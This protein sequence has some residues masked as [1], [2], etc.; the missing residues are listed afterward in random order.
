MNIK[1]VTLAGGSKAGFSREGNGWVIIF[2]GKFLQPINTIVEIE[3]E[4]NVMNVTPAEVLS[5]SLSFMKEV[6]GSSNLKA[7]WINHQWVDLK[8]VNNGDWSGSFWQPAEDD[9][10]PWI[11]INM[12]K[13]VKFSKVVIYESVRNITSFE[14]QYKTGDN[15]NTFYKGSAIGERAELSFK[16]IEAQFIRMVINTYKA[17]PQIY[18]L[19]VIN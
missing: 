16:P 19:M 6:T 11:E 1:N 2:D 14:L 3:Y 15:W 12:G 10:K 7:Q 13:E 8:A 4:G 5:Q 9:K 17:T 18:E